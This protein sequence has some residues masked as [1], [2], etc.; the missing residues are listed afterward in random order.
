MMDR[1]LIKFFHP[2]SQEQWL[3]HYHLEALGHKIIVKL[4]KYLQQRFM[5]KF[6]S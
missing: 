1:M 5:L 2:I 6:Q 3:H 4:Y